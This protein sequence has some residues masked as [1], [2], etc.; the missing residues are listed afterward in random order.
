M[1]FLDFGFCFRRKGANE[2]RQSLTLFCAARL[3]LFEMAHV[4]GIPETFF[5]CLGLFEVSSTISPS[6]SWLRFEGGFVGLKRVAVSRKGLS[7]D[8]VVE[9]PEIMVI[10]SISPCS[11][12]IRL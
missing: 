11:E 2:V 1:A 7:R 4:H 3:Q 12:W 8:S 6:S 5:G 10:V 9:M